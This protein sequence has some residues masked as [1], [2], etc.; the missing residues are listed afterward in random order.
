MVVERST[1]QLVASLVIPAVV[2]H[3]SVDFAKHFTKRIGR[4]QKWGPSIFGLAI[5]PLL[6][7]FLDEP[8][9]QAI[10]WGFKRFGPW[11][12]SATSGDNSKKHD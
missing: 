11:A 10:E 4:F 8:A 9:E 5:I 3:S 7:V 12:T 1:F 2:I 6:P